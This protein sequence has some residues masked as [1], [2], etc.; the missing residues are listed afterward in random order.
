M[1]SICKGL[2]RVELCASLP[3]PLQ[4]MSR[5]SERLG[6]RLLVKREDQTGLAF[7]GNKIRNHEFIFGDIVAQGCDAV[8]TTAGVQSNMCRAT[9][10]AASRLGMSCVLLL[11]GSGD[12]AEQ[13]NLLLDQLLGADVRFIQTDDPYDKRVPGWLDE[14]REELM[15]KGHKPYVLH[16]TGETS[17]LAVC[18]YVSGAE[19]LAAQFRE[20][21][22]VPEWVYVTT[23]SGITAAGLALGFKHLGLPTRVVGISSNSSS[24]FLAERMVQYAGRASNRVGLTTH[25]DARD[26]DVLDAYVGPGYGKG[27]PEVFE[28]IRMVAREEA[29]LL[30]PVYTGKCMTGLIDQVEK[31]HVNKG[32]SVVFL[33]SGGGPNLFAQSEELLTGVSKSGATMDPPGLGVA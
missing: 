25:L 33:H 17:T 19:E 15:A 20:M 26:F 18:A 5:L 12:E 11:R 14:V 13:G 4:E 7:G 27:Y 31:G 8:I 22:C 29:I 28:T 23:G 24:T 16:L 6:V 9:A 32:A 10:A 30:D 21:D 3:T 1:D 2:P